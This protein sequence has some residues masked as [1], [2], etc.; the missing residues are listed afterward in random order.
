MCK[1]GSIEEERKQRCKKY[2]DDTVKI[3]GQCNV[4]IYK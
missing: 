2:K 4:T 3:G 1:N